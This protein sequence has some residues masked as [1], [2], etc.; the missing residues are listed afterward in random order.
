MLRAYWSN[1][2]GRS[3]EIIS[4]DRECWTI[5]PSPRRRSA[6]PARRASD[7]IGTAG[8]IDGSLHLIDGAHGPSPEDWSHLTLRPRLPW[9]GE[10]P[11]GASRQAVQTLGTHGSDHRSMLQPPPGLGRGLHTD[12]EGGAGP[13]RGIDRQS[14][15]VRMAP[16]PYQGLAGTGGVRYNPPTRAY[17]R[18]GHGQR[19]GGRRFG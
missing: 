15:R 13:Q 11:R 19:P 7:R 5:L 4:I 8:L 10:R 17:G 6:C 9:W 2:T 1:R 16:T 12:G 18:R 14:L 3:R